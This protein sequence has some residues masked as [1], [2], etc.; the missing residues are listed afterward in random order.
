MYMP[1]RLNWISFPS[2]CLKN[3]DMWISKLSRVWCIKDYHL[4]KKNI[5]LLCLLFA[6]YHMA[7]LHHSSAGYSMLKKNFLTLLTF[8]IWEIR[9]FPF[10]LRNIATK[11]AVNRC[12]Y[13]YWIAF[14]R[15]LWSYNCLKKNGKFSWTANAVH[16][17]CH[18]LEAIK[19]IIA[20]KMR[21]NT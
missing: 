8:E 17:I 5:I 14:W 20:V 19:T 15:Q 1:A 6:L 18:S 13:K 4:K 12:K 21:F 9:H 10:I 7:A 3:I 16:L 2:V 11:F